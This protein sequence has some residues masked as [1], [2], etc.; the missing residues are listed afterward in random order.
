MKSKS[1]LFAIGF[2]VAML[3]VIGPVGAQPAP[4]SAPTSDT[5]V[6]PSDVAVQAAKEN[7]QPI[8]AANATVTRS[9]DVKDL[10]L[11][12][13]EYPISGALVPPTGLGQPTADQNLSQVPTPASQPLAWLPPDQLEKILIDNV[14]ASSWKTNGGSAGSISYLSGRFLITQTAENQSA[15]ANLLGELRKGEAVM[16]RIRADWVLLPPGQIDQLL[17]NGADDTTPLPE[18]SRDALQKLSGNT[19]HYS[20]RISCFSGMTVNLASGRARTTVVGAT[21]VV[22]PGT[23]MYDP[24]PQIAQYGL[25]LQVMP[26]MYSDSATLDLLSVASEDAS[27]RP[28]ATT[29]PDGID[30]VDAV[31]QHFHTTVQV[32]LNKPVLVGG[33]TL[34]PTS[35]EP[36]GNQLYLIVEA[37]AQP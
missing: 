20:G 14:D 8:I 9:Y 36:A 29:Q 35:S 22:A 24:T 10:L 15:I 27:G 26:V 16:V 33:M 11:R 28:P 12:V 4:P 13:P 32:P 19:V 37:D 7:L 6:I 23:G 1:G 5:R 2:G 30:R 25:S 3:F 34:E 18:I 21:P 31:V 17:K